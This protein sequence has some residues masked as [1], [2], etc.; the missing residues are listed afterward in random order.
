MLNVP[1]GLLARS[2]TDA[3]TGP[4]AKLLDEIPD[5]ISF[6]AAD[7]TTAPPVLSGLEYCI[8][9]LDVAYAKDATDKAEAVMAELDNLRRGLENDLKDNGYQV[10]TG[11]SEQVDKVVQLFY[12]RPESQF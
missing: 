12:R 10:L 8:S 6:R 7:H 1:Q 2:L 5:D 11:T 9:Q 4:A 3:V